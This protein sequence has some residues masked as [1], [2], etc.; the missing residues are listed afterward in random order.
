MRSEDI[1]GTGGIV[2]TAM[3]AMS[4]A[5]LLTKFG[6]DGNG[7]RIYARQM[8]VRGCGATSVATANL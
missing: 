2:L 6:A 4:C 3:L 1:G 7:R 5:T 8:N